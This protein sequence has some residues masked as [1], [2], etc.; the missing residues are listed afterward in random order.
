LKE[1]EVIQ[2]AAAQCPNTTAAILRIPTRLKNSS[3][4]YG[5]FSVLDGHGVIQPHF[6]PVNIRFG[7]LQRPTHCQRDGSRCIFIHPR[8]TCKYFFR[9]RCM[10]PIVV[11]R[12][13]SCTL[14]VGGETR[15]LQEG[16]AV[17][18][19]DSFQHEVCFKLVTL[20]CTHL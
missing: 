3:L 12:G 4:G 16:K 20:S 7:E 19:D 15:T 2:Q 1:S 9:L 5:M 6:G 17:V 13:G 8:L 18:F 14:T 11:P 10:L